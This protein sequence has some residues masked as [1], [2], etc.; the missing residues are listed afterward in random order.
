MNKLYRGTFTYVDARCTVIADKQIGLKVAHTSIA[1]NYSQLEEYL[2]NHSRFVWS[3][4]PVNV[5]EKPLV[6]KLMAQAA[7][8][9]NVGPMAAVAGVLADLAV[10]DMIATGCNVAVV[11]DGGEI[12]AMSNTPVD[13]AVMAGDT[14]LSGRF[15]FR[16]TD[17]PIGLATSSGRFSHAFSFGDADAATVF[18]KNAG[19]ADAAA[20]AVCNGIR[21][22]FA[23]AAIQSGIEIAK[24]ITG[25]E[26]VL[27]LYDNHVGTWGKIPQLMKLAPTT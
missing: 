16:L 4:K 1:Y 25:V 15:G 3:L 18:C 2:R 12:S 8:I 11:E 5:P 17:F 20:T 10:A 27:I 13:V 6:A 7:R 24:S 26:G 19:L 21:G 9:V 23:G 14:P 22:K